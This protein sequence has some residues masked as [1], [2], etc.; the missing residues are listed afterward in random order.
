MSEVGTPL[1]Q[2]KPTQNRSADAQAFAQAEKWMA[3]IR[4]VSREEAKKANRS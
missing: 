2:P 4:E 3:V 1:P